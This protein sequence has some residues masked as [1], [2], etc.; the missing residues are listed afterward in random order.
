MGEFHTVMGLV[1]AIY[2]KS[3]RNLCRYLWDPAAYFDSMA[4]FGFVL[5][6]I[7]LFLEVEWISPGLCNCRTMFCF[8]VVR[9]SAMV[10]RDALLKYSYYLSSLYKLRQI[11]TRHFQKL[12]LIG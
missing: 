10:S 8:C 7:F 6:V 12:L 1:P 4:V 5:V 9:G 11:S 2:S 3:S